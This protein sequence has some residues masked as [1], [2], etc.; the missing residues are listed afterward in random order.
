MDLGE[1]TTMPATAEPDRRELLR[2][3]CPGGATLVIQHLPNFGTR[4]PWAEIDLFYHGRQYVIGG[5]WAATMRQRLP[6]T[7]DPTV[8]GC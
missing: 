6:W 1:V 2:L 4:E 5:N 7:L 3:P 8:G